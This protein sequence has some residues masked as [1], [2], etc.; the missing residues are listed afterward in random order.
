MAR[1]SY[2][3]DMNTSSVRLLVGKAVTVSD[4]THISPGINCLPDAIA[5]AYV[6]SLKVGNGKES[7]MSFMVGMYYVED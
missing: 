1:F 4:T 7:M 3:R 5:F 6:A 2:S